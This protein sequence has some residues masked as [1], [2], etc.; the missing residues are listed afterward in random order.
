[1]CCCF[2]CIWRSDATSRHSTSFSLK[3]NRIIIYTIPTTRRK[4]F[5]E[6]TTIKKYWHFKIFQ[7]GRHRL[8]PSLHHGDVSEDLWEVFAVH[9][10]L[11]SSDSL[12]GSGTA[13]TDFAAWYLETSQTH[14]FCYRSLTSVMQVKIVSKM[15]TLKQ[16]NHVDNRPEDISIFGLTLCF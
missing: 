5:D 8:L 1:M 4:Y 11:V 6:K 13:Y 14:T 3:S 15:H 10:R 7:F 9:V 16:G 12:S 2:M